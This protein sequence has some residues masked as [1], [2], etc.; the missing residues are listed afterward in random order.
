MVR[1]NSGFT[2]VKDYRR[3]LVNVGPVG[4]F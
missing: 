1:R 3:A 4:V 2:E